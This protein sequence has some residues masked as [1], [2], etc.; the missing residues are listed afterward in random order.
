VEDKDK[1]KEQL[2]HELAEARRQ[3]ALLKKEGPLRKE[4]ADVLIEEKTNCNHW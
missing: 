1:S 2:L 3:V 4:T